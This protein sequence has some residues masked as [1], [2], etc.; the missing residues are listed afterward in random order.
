M[1]ASMPYVLGRR[2]GAPPGTTFRLDVTGQ[3][4]RTVQLVV[5]RDAQG[6]PRAAST[7]VIEGSP[8]AALLVDEETFVRRACGRITAGALRAAPQTAAAG[9]ASL[10]DEFIERMVVM[11]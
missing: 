10:V 3:L 4:G 1:E 7:P 9:D 2:V 6:K 8:T 5:T 11:V